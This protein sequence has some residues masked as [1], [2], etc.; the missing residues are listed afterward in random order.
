MQNS[1]LRQLLS[2]VWWIQ[3]TTLST[4]TVFS[5]PPFVTLTNNVRTRN[6]LNLSFFYSSLLPLLLL[7][8][9]HDRDLFVH[10]RKRKPLWFN[11]KLHNIFQTHVK[12]FHLYR[13]LDPTTNWRATQ[14]K[15]VMVEVPGSV[16]TTASLSLRL[17]QTVLAF[18][19]LLFM[20][21]GVRFYQ[22]TAFW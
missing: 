6:T 18:G 2:F 14:E 22:F 9:D 21:I 8:H 13:V 11:R 4:W 1:F 16:G 5:F 17:G 15:L 19:S 3:T 7:R 20:T 10:T 12:S